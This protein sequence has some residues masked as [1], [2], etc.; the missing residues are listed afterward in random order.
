M[1]ECDRKPLLVVGGKLY[2]Y[3]NTAQRANI[4]EPKKSLSNSKLCN[5][6]ELWSKYYISLNTKVSLYL[7]TYLSIIYNYPSF[8]TLNIYP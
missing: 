4:T 3:G 2:P 5:Y 1:G 8:L 7:D 6:L